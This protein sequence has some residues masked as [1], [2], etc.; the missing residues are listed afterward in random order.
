MS[1]ALRIRLMLL[2]QQNYVGKESDVAAPTSAQRQPRANCFT[3]IADVE[4][5][6]LIFPESKGEISQ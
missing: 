6:E 5:P 2:W 4:Q 3:D 1:A